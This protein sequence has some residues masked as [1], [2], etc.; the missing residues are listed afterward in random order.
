MFFALFVFSTS[1][2]PS[3]H[4]A[5]AG[6]YADSHFPNLTSSQRESFLL[7]AMYADGVDK[8]ISHF[9]RPIVRELNSIANRQSNLY[10]FLLGIF[11]HISIDTFAHSGLANSYIVPRGLKHHLSELVVCSWAHRNLSPRYITLSQELKNQISGIGIGFK[12]SF[13]YMYPLCYFFAKFFPAHWFLPYVHQGN[14]PVRTYRDADCTFR[15]H[16]DAMV[17]AT[18]NLMALC[19][20]PSLNEIDVKEIV[21]AQLNSIECCSPDQPVDLTESLRLDERHYPM[22]M[23]G[24]IML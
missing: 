9:V 11:S 5:F 22:P 23:S 19:H 10:W 15:R 2:T 7:G 12:K 21:L 13:R 6:Y 8:S 4:Q 14:C 18:E 20:D 16:L 24:S 1:W 3:F 17:K